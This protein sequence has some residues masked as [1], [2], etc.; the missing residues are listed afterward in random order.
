MNSY[1]ELLKRQ[2]DSLE[3]ALHEEKV[4]R[5]KWEN[6]AR[7]LRE[8]IEKKHY[9]WDDEMGRRNKELL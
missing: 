8:A 4:T 2:K 9:N 1:I 6:E 3:D 5:M 7:D